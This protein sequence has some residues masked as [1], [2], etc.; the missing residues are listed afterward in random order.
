MKYQSPSSP[1]D[2]PLAA[3]AQ[4]KMRPIV[5]YVAVQWQFHGGVGGPKLWLGPAI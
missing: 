4:H 5:T 3:H 1:L 2:T